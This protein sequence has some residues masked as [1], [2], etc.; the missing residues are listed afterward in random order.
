[1]I[2]KSRHQG[3]ATLFGELVGVAVVHG[4]RGHQANAA[5]TMH[6]VVPAEEHL[7]VRASIFDRA[8][9]CRE[10][11]PILQGFELRFGVRIVIRDMGPAVRFADIQVHE[12]RGDR[13]RAHAAAALGVQG[14]RAGDDVLF[15]SRV[16][17]DLL[18]ELGRFARRDHPADDIA[19]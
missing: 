8:E 18:G 9:A 13:L 7:A 17:D 12:Q 10:V 16:G 19:G 5:V 4:V 2:G 15:V 3:D 11:R 6:G 14:Q 1:M